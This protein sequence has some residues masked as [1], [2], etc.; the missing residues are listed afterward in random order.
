MAHACFVPAKSRCLDD[1]PNM[2]ASECVY[3]RLFALFAGRD[4]TQIRLKP[5]PRIEGLK[6]VSRCPKVDKRNPKQGITGARR[7]HPHSQLFPSSKK[8]AGHGCGIEMAATESGIPGH[9][10]NEEVPPGG[11]WLSAQFGVSCCTLLGYLPGSV[12]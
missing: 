3:K 12:R 4:Q 11:S 7:T 6:P 10:D 1:E 5:H 8:S 9:R 2:L